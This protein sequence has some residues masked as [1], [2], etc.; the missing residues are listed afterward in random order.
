MNPQYS[1]WSEAIAKVCEGGRS[2]WKVVWIWG[3]HFKRTLWFQEGSFQLQLE[4]LALYMSLGQAVETLCAVDY[5]FS[6]SE[7]SFEPLVH[8]KGRSFEGQEDQLSK[9]GDWDEIEGTRQ[10]RVQGFSWHS[11]NST[12]KSHFSILADNVVRYAQFTQRWSA[13][14]TNHPSWVA[15]T[16]S[17]EF[18]RW[19]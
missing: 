1:S 18:V 6:H 5:T 11:T 4:G 2:D 7:P 8:H 17:P 19:M 12:P 10:E 15:K 14:S 16:E 13:E 3:I 9:C